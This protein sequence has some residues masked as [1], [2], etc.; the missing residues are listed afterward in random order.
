MTYLDT[1][2]NAIYEEVN[3][4]GMPPEDE[5]SLYR[6]YAVLALTVGERVTWENVH[7]AWAAWKAGTDPSHPA[8]KPFSHLDRKAQAKDA[9]FA[10]AIRAVARRLMPSAS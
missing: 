4:R 10:E 8:V 7:D 1:L 6:I 9:P 3:G 2:A 5:R